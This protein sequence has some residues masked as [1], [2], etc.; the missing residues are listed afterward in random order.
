MRLTPAA[1]A[2]LPVELQKQ[3]VITQQARIE[4]MLEVKTKYEKLGIEHSVSPFFDN[5]PQLMHQAHVVLGRSGTGSIS[6]LAI[7]NRAA[8]L[9]PLRLA[10]GHQ[11]DNAKILTKAGAAIMLEE[12][13]LTPES[14]ARE[15]KELLT[16]PTK[17]ELF[18]KNA[19]LIAKPQAAQD[20]AD[21]IMK[22]AG[23]DRVKTPEDTADE[24]DE[25]AAKP[26]AEPKTAMD[27]ANE[28]LG[29]DI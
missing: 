6:E 14:L 19:A 17:R 28:K 7:L 27:I 8:I 11:I 20:A 25:P 2:E 16:R 23:L 12:H 10:D 18:E 1:I 26:K 15:L 24:T 4:D 29:D 22:L 3:L 21:E 5:L 9:V 13:V